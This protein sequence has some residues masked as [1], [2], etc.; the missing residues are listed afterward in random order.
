MGKGN[1]VAFNSGDSLIV[2]IGGWPENTVLGFLYVIRGK[3]LDSLQVDTRFP[4][5]VI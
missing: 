2:G 3:G 5:T 4:Y 1:L